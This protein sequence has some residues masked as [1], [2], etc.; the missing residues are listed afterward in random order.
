V[1]GRSPLTSAYDPKRA[2]HCDPT[3]LNGRRLRPRLMLTPSRHR[4]SHGVTMF[5]PS[6]LRAMVIILVGAG[7]AG[8]WVLASGVQ[9]W[10]PAVIIFLLTLC[11]LLIAQPQ[12][13]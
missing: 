11:V 1:S 7:I 4:S 2:W 13:D 9:S 10:W 3:L 5:E 8:A 6:R 12:D